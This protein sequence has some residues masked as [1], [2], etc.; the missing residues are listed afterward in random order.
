AFLAKISDPAFNLV[1]ELIST[2]PVHVLAGSKNVTM[3]LS[4]ANFVADSVIRWNGTER[5]TTFKSSIKLQA[6]LLDSDVAQATEAQVTVFNPGPGGGVSKGLS[7]TIDPIPVPM[8][9]IPVISGIGPNIVI[10]PSGPLQL[11]VTGSG[12]TDGSVVRFNGSD[13]PTIL[14]PSGV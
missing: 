6:P 1:P 4:G 7:F 9:P 13:R 14:I 11:T 2:V 10:V 12:F 5:P 3:T 8:N